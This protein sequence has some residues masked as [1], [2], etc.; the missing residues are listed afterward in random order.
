VNKSSKMTLAPQD[1]GV[2][3]TMEMF[4]HKFRRPADSQHDQDDEDSSG[5]ATVGSKPCILPSGWGKRLKK[6]SKVYKYS[7]VEVLQYNNIRD[8]FGSHTA[9]SWADR[10]FHERY[11][12]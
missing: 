2:L 5:S 10:R 11:D 9:K 6:P 12:A 3:E 1:G 4:Q 7:A 8:E